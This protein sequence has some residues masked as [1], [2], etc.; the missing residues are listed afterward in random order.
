MGFSS[1]KS[2]K[3]APGIR[4]NLSKRGLSASGGVRGLRASVDTKGEQLVSGG[5]GGVYFR[6]RLRKKR[7]AA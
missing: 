3:I 6:R 7:D 1:R 2:F 4:L 5:R